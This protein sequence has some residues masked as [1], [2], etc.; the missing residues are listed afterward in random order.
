[1]YTKKFRFP[2]IIHIL[3]GE[4]LDKTSIVNTITGGFF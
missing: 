4:I 1:M 2:I 3:A